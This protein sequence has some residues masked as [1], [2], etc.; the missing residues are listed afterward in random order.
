MPTDNNKADREGHDIPHSER[1]DRGSIDR[2]INRRNVLLAGLAIGGRA[3]LAACGASGSG[4]TSTASTAGAASTE[5]AVETAV[6]SADPFSWPTDLPSIDG[7]EIVYP[8]WGG[9]FD[10]VVQSK[11]N[12]LFEEKTGCKATFVP[13]PDTAKLEEMVRNNAVE[14]DL[15]TAGPDF[16]P[17]IFENPNP[18][19][20]NIDYS[21]VAAGAIPADQ[22]FERMVTT[23]GYS[24]GLVYR[25]DK[26]GD[27]PPQSWAMS[28]P[29]KRRV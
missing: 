1:F 25:T 27:S 21:I 3:F 17:S 23:D 5:S 16:P 11:V 2:A 12:S 7:Q 14:W 20:E 10:E 8:G 13:G 18:T 24:L 9:P 6:E 28:S 29:Q 22:Q 15:W 26:F 19:F 4:G